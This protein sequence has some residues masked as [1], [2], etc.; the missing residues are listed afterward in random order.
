VEAGVVGTFS[1]PVKHPAA[2]IQSVVQL[3]EPILRFQAK[4]KKCKEWLP[5][6][7]RFLRQ[8]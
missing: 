4:V 6:T 8:I 7:T 3:P 2:Q 5:S 1:T